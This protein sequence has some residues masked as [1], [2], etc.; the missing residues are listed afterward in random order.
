MAPY[1]FGFS[2][3][4][5]LLIS[6]DNLASQQRGQTLADISIQKYKSVLFYYY[7]KNTM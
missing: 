2:V 5:S 6:G 4:T 7:M 3:R 1:T